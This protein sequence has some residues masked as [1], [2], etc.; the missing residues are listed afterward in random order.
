MRIRFVLHDVY[1]SGGGVLRVVLNLAA[2]L[3]QRHEVELVSVLRRREVP[4]HPLPEGVP[5]RVLFD[6]RAV[7]GARGVG[8][9]RG[10]AHRR[11]S[12]LML[13]QDARYGQHSLYTDLLLA[14]YVRSVRDGVL[15]GMQP[16]ISMAIARFARDSVV[17]V[18]QE[19]RPFV[20]R[21]KPMQAAMLRY[22]PR[23]DTFL[24]LTERDAQSYRERFDGRVPVQ[25]MPNGLT[26]HPGATSN[27]RNKVVVAAGRLRRGKGFDRLVS[28]WSVVAER[29]PDWRLRIFGSGGQR[30][31]LRKQ[32]NDLGLQKSVQLMGYREDVRRRMARGSIFVLSSRAEGYPMALL[33]AMSCGLVVVAFDCPTGPRE[34]ITH[35][36]DGFLV[37]NGDIDGL[38]EAINRTIELGEER[39]PIGA[40]ALR[41]AAGRSE[42]AIAA[43]WEELFAALLEARR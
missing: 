37:P 41:T 5:V 38:A 22:Y 33:E 17:R 12:R 40:A 23:L 2:E 39:R 7:A 36:V 43:R 4:V 25:V 28:A 15:V 6:R 26:P 21:A 16:G 13:P 19:H 8:R 10:W 9:L 32:V 18:A 30:P 42:T 35:G 1:G 20:S 3:A 31:A 34:I 24:T 14:L 11:P 27:Q 29:H